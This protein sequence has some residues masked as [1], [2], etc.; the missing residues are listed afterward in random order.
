MPSAGAASSPGLKAK[1]VVTLSG[2][3]NPLLCNNIQFPQWPDCKNRVSH[4]VGHV[5]KQINGA[6]SM[7]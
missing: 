4:R 5:S 1:E 2:L 7:S 6:H 3:Q